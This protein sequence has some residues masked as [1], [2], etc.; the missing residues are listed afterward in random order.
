[1]IDLLN[2]FAT[3]FSDPIAQLFV[4]RAAIVGLLVGAPPGLTS[5][6][7]IAILVPVTL[8][9]EPLHAL[10][11]LVVFDNAFASDPLC[12]PFRASMMTGKYPQSH[13]MT[14]NHFP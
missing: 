10:A 5:A 12:C 6:A 13:G 3:L 9:M 11:A 2:G 1:M 4:L 14:Q 8:Y 7:A